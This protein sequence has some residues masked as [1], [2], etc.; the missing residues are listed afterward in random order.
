MKNIRFNQLLLSIVLLLA[1]AFCYSLTDLQ[2]EFGNASGY[3]NSVPEIEQVNLSYDVDGCYIYMS[4]LP[5]EEEDN[6]GFNLYRNNEFLD[7]IERETYAW[8]YYYA[9]YDVINMNQYSYY[10][11]FVYDDGESDPS[12]TV[13]VWVLYPPYPITAL[14]YGDHVVITWEAP[15]EDTRLING[16][17][18]Y[19]NFELLNPEPVTELAYIDYDVNQGMLYNY[20]VT[21]VYEDMG[22]SAESNC[23]YVI[24]EDKVDPPQ[25]ILHTV[26]IDEVM[27]SWERPANNGNWYRFDDD[28]VGGAYVSDSGDFTAVIHYDLMD[29]FNYNNWRLER[30]SF[31]PLSDEGTYTFE[32]WEKSPW[33]PDT[34]E[35]WTQIELEDIVPN[36][37]NT[38]PVSEWDGPVIAG[39]YTQFRIAI[40]CEGVNA[41][42]AY[43]DSPN[44]HE[45]SD[46]L[47]ID[48]N[49]TNLSEQGIDANWKIR[50][51]MS[52]PQPFVPGN[53]IELLGYNLYRDDVLITQLA[54]INEHFIETGLADGVYQYHMTA[55]YEI[56]IGFDVYYIEFESMESELVTVSVGIT[57]VEKDPVQEIVTNDVI[58]HNYPNPFNPDTT[59]T[60]SLN[61]PSRVQIDI[62]N[63]QGRKVRSLVAE[64]FSSGLHQIVWDGTDDYRKPVGSGVYFSRMTTKKSTST[65]KM[66]LLK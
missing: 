38:V 19:K 26:D 9:D 45:R 32:L 39:G 51:Y 52:P 60:F 50:G 4:W 49:E 59:I 23:F 36:E 21:A 62:Y 64:E 16:Y 54:E 33:S 42:I 3:R 22:E 2:P 29:L 24:V 15:E 1:A 13:A 8:G 48:G 44:M 55:V 41:G 34:Y 11:T 7:Y 43:D 6:I 10:L 28:T 5:Y 40:R 57:G 37:W 56:E 31:V 35:L 27:L 25:N 17:N 65:N 14:P 46:L 47:I 66:L 12:E 20:L 30:I 61:N 63:I 18:I 53:G 58:L